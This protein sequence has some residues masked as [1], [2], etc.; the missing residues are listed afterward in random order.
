[1]GG[2]EDKGMADVMGDWPIV[3]C[4]ARRQ[5]LGSFRHYTRPLVTERHRRWM[6]ATQT[7]LCQSGASLVSN[8]TVVWD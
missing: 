5:E 7:E 2:N 1:M 8:E 3:G 6:G 4:R